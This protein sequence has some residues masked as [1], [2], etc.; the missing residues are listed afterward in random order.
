MK[1]THAQSGLCVV[2]FAYACFT[3]V[4]TGETNEIG[5]GKERKGKENVYFFLVLVLV[6]ISCMYTLNFSVLVLH[7]CKSRLY[8]A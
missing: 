1:N 4:H 3:D 6:F 5:K 7:K 2:F 8:V